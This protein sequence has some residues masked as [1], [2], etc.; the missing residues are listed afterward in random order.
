MKKIDLGQ[1]TGILAN[2]GVIAGIVFLALELQ[3]NNELM[4][5][6]ARRNRSAFAEQVN[7]LM[8]TDSV[9]GPLILK[10]SQGEPFTA[11]ESF[12][13]KRFWF[14]GLTNLETAFFDFDDVELRAQ[15]G[16]WRQFF[17]NNRALREVWTENAAILDAEFVAW[18]NEDVISQPE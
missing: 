11:L 15:V 17:G 16:R 2:I 7:L 13:L 9:L 18:I 3:Q 4:E 10:D 12:R 14:A 6:E 5:S 1:V 8:A